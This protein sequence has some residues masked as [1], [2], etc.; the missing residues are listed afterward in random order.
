MAT[1]VLEMQFINASGRSS[2][3]RLT[4]VKDPYTGA[5]AQVLMDTILNKNIFTTTGGDLAT[6]DS[7]RIVVTDV[8]DLEL[9]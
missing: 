2:T 6:K 8:T 3:I 1:R 5:E 9:S 7:A 4:N